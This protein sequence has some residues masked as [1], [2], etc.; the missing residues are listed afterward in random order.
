MGTE[1][2]GLTAAY[3]VILFPDVFGKAG[4]QSASLT[5]NGAT[6]SVRGDLARQ[7]F[8]RRLHSRP[9]NDAVFYVDW[10]R[11]EK[12]MPDHSIDLRAEGRHLW[13]ELRA[14]GYAVAGGEV[15]DTHGWGSWR[16]HTDDL[17]VA[18]FPLD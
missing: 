13:A 4:V 5:L 10:N 3:G 11:Y 15:L 18:L 2:F 12:C 16:A 9:A 6:G 8:F 14:K 17:L 1:A 7:D